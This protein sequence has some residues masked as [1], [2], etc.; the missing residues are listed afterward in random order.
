[1]AANDERCCRP[2]FWVYLIIC[3]A[4]VAFAGLMSGLTLGLMSLSRLNLE[5]LVKAGQ[6][7]DR[8]NAGKILPVVKNQ[9]L[10]L[11][12]LL[13][14]NALAMEALP[15]FL[16]ALIPAWG[17]ILVS[18]T[19][20][21]SFGEII[22]QA[23]C[24]R[25]GLRVGAKMVM[26]VRLLLLV[27][28]PISYPISKILDFLL[29]KESSTLLRRAELKTFVHMHGNEE[30]R[31]GELTRDETT[32]ISGALDLTQKTAK[33]PMTPISETFSLDITA[34]LDKH[35]MGLI[36]SKGHS[37]VP[38][39]S[40]SP[41]NIIGLILVKNLINCL[42]EDET[43]I[44]NLTIRKNPRVYD[45]LPL[46]AI[47][48]EFQKGHSHMAVVLKDHRK[49]TKAIVGNS[50]GMTSFSLTV[51]AARNPFKKKR[52]VGESSREVNA[53][54]HESREMRA[55]IETLQSQLESAHLSTKEDRQQL[56]SL[57]AS[58]NRELEE[59]RGMIASLSSKLQ[60]QQARQFG[61]IHQAEVVVVEHFHQS[62]EFEQERIEA[63]VPSLKRDFKLCHHF[64]RSQYLDID[65]S[66]IFLRSVPDD[67]TREVEEEATTLEEVD[68][69]ED[70][71]E[72]GNENDD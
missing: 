67:L 65:L 45:Y 54:K 49:D 51:N 26:L 50:R 19:L 32:I 42:P 11:C 4:L 33:D 48:N 62:P 57:S 16:D 24:S 38:I 68:N 25:Y 29:G 2:M 58:M 63:V 20:V 31:G 43:P 52:A 69:D 39:Y 17:A 1:M 12:T 56:C 60:G 53:L 70:N 21:L 66:S 44:R 36:T 15:V 23:V 59:V 14:C 35:T 10:L 64:L 5:V 41:S 61:D 13:I 46:Y 9:H 18:V 22:P 71:S 30:G 8:K 47:L 6:P 28:F 37:R 72:G 40:G 7:Q 3:G 55:N 27:F 34:K